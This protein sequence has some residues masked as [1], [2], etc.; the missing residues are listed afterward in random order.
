M[1][2]KFFVQTGKAT[3]K[4]KSGHE[5]PALQAWFRTALA[6]GRK[7]DRKNLKTAGGKFIGV[8]DLVK[9]R[10]LDIA[11]ETFKRQKRR[12]T[13]PDSPLAQLAEKYSIPPKSLAGLFLTSS[14][15]KNVARSENLVIANTSKG[16]AALQKI[17]DIAYKDMA[18]KIGKIPYIFNPDINYNVAY[19]EKIA[20]ALIQILDKAVPGF[21]LL[22]SNTIS[23]AID[24]YENN[25][26]GAGRR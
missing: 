23:K 8:S 25:R 18:D 9:A 6:E 20:S 17:M 7:F 26:H 14:K 24:D 16:R 22:R 21:A 4:Y 1:P 19:A 5:I 3:L 11:R 2:K 10:N 13:S 15:R 12:L